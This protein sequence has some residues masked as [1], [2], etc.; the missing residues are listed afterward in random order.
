MSLKA[1]LFDLDGVIVDTAKY[2]Y[3]AWKQLADKLGIY[4][5]EE[6]NE[7]LKGVSRMASLEIILE[8]SSKTYTEEEKEAL[9]TEKNDQYVS[10][11]KRITPAEILPGVTVF[12][13]S[14]K[15]AG[16]KSAV[17]SAS[18]SAGMIIDLLDLNDFFD[19][20]LGGA[21]VTRPKPDPEIFTLARDRFGLTSDECLVVE[22]A[23]AGIEAA[24]NAGMKALG[25]GDK[26][27]LTNAVVVYRD[28]TDFTLE[29]AQKLFRQK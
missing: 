4:F 6:I 24:K 8:R 28:M 20:V 13:Q 2:H 12:L 23:F 17:C 25:I 19:A 16:I 7:R 29:D 14:L 10:M 11:V 22:D 5:D 18:K 26:T 3:I 27:I 15:E 21:D 9:A 1:V